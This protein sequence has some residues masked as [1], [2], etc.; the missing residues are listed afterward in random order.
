MLEGN[1]IQNLNF[2]P[3][4]RRPLPHP[5]FEVRIPDARSYE[6]ECVLRSLILTQLF[7]AL[8]VVFPS[9]CLVVFSCSKLPD[10]AAN[11]NK[12]IALD[13][14]GNTVEAVR[15]RSIAAGEAV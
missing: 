7:C 10:R 6:N 8:V 15:L 1:R 3:P 2:E 14:L 12:P 9:L 13:D 11:G 5:L 4:V